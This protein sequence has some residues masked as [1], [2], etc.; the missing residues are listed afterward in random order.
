MTKMVG[1]ADP[2]V[3]VNLYSPFSSRE[4]AVKQIIKKDTLGQ[5]AY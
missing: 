3:F 5:F 4:L 2:R 1:F